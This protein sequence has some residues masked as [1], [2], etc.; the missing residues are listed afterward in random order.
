MKIAMDKF[1]LRI[2]YNKKVLI[3][4][5][6]L[7]IIALATGSIFS[8]ML[9]NSDKNLVATYIANFFDSINNNTINSTDALKNGLISAC[10]YILI[11]WV[12]GISV[13][14]IIITLFMYFTKVFI[15][16]FSISSIINN[17]GIKGCLLA[18]SYIFPHEVINIIVYTILTM[19][20]I[21]VSGKIIYAVLKKEKMDFKAIMNRYLLILG[22]SILSII[23]T[24][25]FEVFLTPK[26]IKIVLPLIKTK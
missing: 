13:I 25:L 21:K 26:L 5:I 4:L 14:G 24:T 2:K 11:I 19:Y 7:G 20:T 17:Y 6:V 3:F 22:I 10:S 16:G 18:L 12:M 1:K 8:V 9:N 15:L 23:V